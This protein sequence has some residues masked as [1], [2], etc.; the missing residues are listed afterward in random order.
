[1]KTVKKEDIIQKLSEQIEVLKEDKNILA[2]Q[3]EEINKLVANLFISQNHLES[4]N[5]KQTI[6]VANISHELRTALNA[7]LGFS[8]V[9]NDEVF[10]PIENKKYKEYIKFIQS[11]SNHLLSLVNEIL[12]LSKIQAN[13]M[14]LHETTIDLKQ[15]LQDAIFIALQ[16]DTKNNRNIVLH[17][18]NHIILRAD[19]KL[20]KQ[21]FLNVLSNAVKFTKKEEKID[22]FVKKT[23]F[24]IRLIFKDN[25]IGIPKEKINKLF[26]PFEQIENSFSRTNIGS[27]L[28][29]VLVKK[30]VILHGGRI[31]IKSLYPKGVAVLIDLP[32]KRI[33]SLG[34]KN[35]IS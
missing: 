25:G 31:E 18:M 4:L 20:M 6:F 35:E 24:G 29:L 5:K 32:Q 26:Q 27:G 1:M 16:F 17:K 19:E 7:I 28:G 12:D 33:V 21:I 10:G 15:L 9:M 3:I 8:Q 14:F 34:A 23:S 13:K 22:V 11:N 30:M 2:H